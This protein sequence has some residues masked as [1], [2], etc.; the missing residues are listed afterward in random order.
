[1]VFRCIG[2]EGNAHSPSP[3]RRF[4]FTRPLS[5]VI[6]PNSLTVIH[7]KTLFNSTIATEEYKTNSSGTHH[8][9]KIVVR[10]PKQQDLSNGTKRCHGNPQVTG[11]SIKE[12]FNRAQLL[13]HPRKVSECQYQDTI[14]A[15]EDGNVVTRPCV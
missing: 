7:S 12:I 6:F 9:S 5:T 3:S 11:A 10:S 4:A 15:V 2:E 8:A 1:M 14:S 13:L